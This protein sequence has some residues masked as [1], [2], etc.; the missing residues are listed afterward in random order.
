MFKG[1]TIQIRFVDTGRVGQ[2]DDHDA[3]IDTSVIV[4]AA[5]PDNVSV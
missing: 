3:D 2:H 5:F 4:K 1:R